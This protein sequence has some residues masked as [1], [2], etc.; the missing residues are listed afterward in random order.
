[1]KNHKWQL[2]DKV[3]LP[4]GSPIMEV[5]GFSRNGRVWCDWDDSTRPWREEGSFVPECLLPACQV[6]SERFG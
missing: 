4:S 3:V 1:M 6:P 5:I 2:G